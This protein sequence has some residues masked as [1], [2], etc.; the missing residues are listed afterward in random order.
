MPE[1][2]VE[3]EIALPSP[4]LVILAGPP[5]SGKTTWAHS[6]FPDATVSS[7]QLRA[8]AGDSAGDM[9]ASAVALKLLDQIVAERVRRGL[10]TVVDTLGTDAD[11]RAQW[12]SVASSKGLPVFLVTF[13]TSAAS[14]RRL[15]RS[16]DKRVPDEVMRRAL[17]AWPDQ[18]QQ[19]VAESFHAVHSVTADAP[20]PARARTVS[21]EIAVAA[22]KPPASPRRGLGFGLLLGRFP[23]AEGDRD[24]HEFD[25]TLAAAEAAGFDSIWVMDHFRQIPQVGRAWDPML[26]AWS[27]IA[28]IAAKT[29]RVRVGSLVTCASHRNVGLLAKTVATVDVL[30]GGRVICGLGAGWF[31]QE[32]AAYGYEVLPPARRLDVLE[33]TLEALPVLW[34]KGAKAYTGRTLSVPEAMGYPRPVQDPLP[35]L[36]GGNG[37]QRTLLLAARHAAMCNVMGDL[38]TVRQKL[39]VLDRHLDAEGRERDTIQ[40]TALSKALVAP[41]AS[42]LAARI[43]QLRPARV[44]PERFAT[45]SSA[46]TVDDH[47]ARYRAASAA[48]VDTAIVALADLGPESVETFGG[49]IDQFRS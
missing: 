35:L 25:E 36:V 22:E 40:R 17:T 8:L 45:A 6:N 23:W 39:Q 4:C 20:A 34:G 16:R 15:N 37:E 19:L 9:A 49:V 33:D 26:E 18:R 44:S 3:E 14:C 12:R 13:D 5:A 31:D 41:D 30:S 29:E 11:A 24:P 7:D 28:W 46:G 43:D 1:D 38:E 21:A 32:Q 10:T 2:E 47:V 27:T 48:G 42:S